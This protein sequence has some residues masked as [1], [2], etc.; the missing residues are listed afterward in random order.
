MFEEEIRK[1]VEVDMSEE[2]LWGGV[3]C[4]E[5][6]F[7]IE[8]TYILPHHPMHHCQ[9]GSPLDFLCLP[10]VRGYSNLF[11]GASLHRPIKHNQIER[12]QPNR[13]GSPSQAPLLKLLPV[14]LFSSRWTQ[15]E[16]VPV[17]A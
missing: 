4:Y 1:N 15:A 12:G 2:Y 5:R 6:Y 8:L 16:E 13:R 9:R 3:R 11:F 10:A 14:L 7:Q 17:N